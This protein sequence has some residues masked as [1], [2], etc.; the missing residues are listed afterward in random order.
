MN[1]GIITYN[2]KH[3]KTQDIFKRINK[4]KFKKITLLI[5]NFKNLKKEKLY[6]NTDLINLLVLI[7]FP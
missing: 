5:T 6:L 7:L 1:L 4:R 3:K 2:K